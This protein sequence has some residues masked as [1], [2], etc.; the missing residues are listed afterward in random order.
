MYFGVKEYAIADYRQ[1]SV[2]DMPSHWKSTS[3][4]FLEAIAMGRQFV[5]TKKGYPWLPGN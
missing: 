2:Y 3:I 4:T 5:T 1:C